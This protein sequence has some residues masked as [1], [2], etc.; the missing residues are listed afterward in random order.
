[1]GGTILV[2]DMNL[3]A[4]LHMRR[5]I[6]QSPRQREA[7]FSVED[8]TG[9]LS[10]IEKA[11]AYGLV[12]GESPEIEGLVST[13]DDLQYRRPGMTFISGDALTEWLRPLEERLSKFSLVGFFLSRSGREWIELRERFREAL[14]VPGLCVFATSEPDE[15]PSRNQ[16]HIVNPTPPVLVASRELDAWPGIVLWSPTGHCALIPMSELLEV[17]NE[18]REVGDAARHQ[19]VE[20]RRLCDAVLVARGGSRGSP[21]LLQLSDLHFGTE[22]AATNQVYLLNHL[23]RVVEEVGRVLITG[24]LMDIPNPDNLRQVDAFVSRIAS[25]SKDKPIVIPGNHDER[26]TWG[27]LWQSLKQVVQ[28]D[29]QAVAVDHGLR[30][31][32]LGFDSTLDSN[33]AEGFVSEE[34]TRRVAAQLELEIS[35]S[36]EVKD[37]LQVALVHHHPLPLEEAKDEGFREHFEEYWKEKVLGMRDGE[38][39]LKW[40]AKRE[41]RLVLHGH[42]HRPRRRDAWMSIGPS[43][44]RKVMVVG[45]GTSLGVRGRPLGYNLITWDVTGK[46]WSVEFLED[47]RD[48]SRFFPSASGFSQEPW[49]M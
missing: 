2:D 3:L 23:D 11:Q 29:H 7:T 10:R 34:Q 18:L 32:F 19:P 4:R 22:E 42:K 37:Y 15:W 26:K 49:A 46:A 20:K 31:V 1:M 38:R 27:S 17:L 5:A 44:L 39:F 28:L 30:C 24:D 47:E 43:E 6:L 14:S 9:S 13:A 48:G 36:P 25:R 41:A 45:C 8:V 40:C 12:F 21:K 16:W 33:L 35:R